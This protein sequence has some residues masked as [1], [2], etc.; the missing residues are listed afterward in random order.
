MLVRSIEPD[1]RFIVIRTNFSQFFFTCLAFSMIDRILALSFSTFYDVLA[2]SMYRAGLGSGITL[3]WYSGCALGDVI[4]AIK[5]VSQKTQPY[6][7]CMKSA[8]SIVVDWVPGS[9]CY[10]SWFLSLVV[11]CLLSFVNW[12]V[13][14]GCQV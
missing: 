5:S 6:L 13:A 11:G 1:S 8:D 4:L 12:G 7:S 10:T 3:L 14:F 9:R 2:F